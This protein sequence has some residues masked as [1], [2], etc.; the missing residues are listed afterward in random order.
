MHW[1]LHPWAC[2]SVM[3]L[4][5]AYF[6]FRKKESAMVSNLFKPMLGTK[7]AQG[8]IGK[9]IDIFTTVLTVIGVATSFGMGCLQICSG[10]EDLF[11]I[12]NNM[13]TW[14]VVIIIICFIYLKRKN[15]SFLIFSFHR[16]R[17][18]R[19]GGFWPGKTAPKFSFRQRETEDT[20]SSCLRS[21]CF[22]AGPP[23]R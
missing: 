14:I 21:S 18:L 22:P 4:G 23:A 1:G 16:D 7:Q 9:F 8:G 20:G 3:G 19:N 5:L 17:W 10:L 2:Y 12:P 6:Q 11:S 15:S 13:L